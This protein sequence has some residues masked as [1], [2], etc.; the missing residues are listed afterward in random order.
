MIKMLILLDLLGAWLV[1][2]YT[3]NYVRLRDEQEEVDGKDE[4][5]KAE[6]SEPEIPELVIDGECTVTRRRV[7]GQ[8]YR[9]SD[10]VLHRD[11]PRY[12]V[13]VELETPIDC[14]S[15]VPMKR[16]KLT[17]IEPEIEFIG[18]VCSDGKRIIE[19]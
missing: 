3:I 11:F 16:V 10:G 12:K 6:S 15:V 14:D 8:T 19:Y 9:D 13:E 7:D 18:H 5:P 2:I 1:V 17:R 4:K